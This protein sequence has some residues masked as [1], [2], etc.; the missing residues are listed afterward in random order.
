MTLIS[1]TSTSSAGLV[2]KGGHSVGPRAFVRSRLIPATAC[3]VL[4]SCGGNDLATGESATTA[5]AACNA[6]LNQQFEGATITKAG[7][8][9]AAGSVPEACVVRGELPKELAFE[10]RMPTTWNNRVLFMGGGGFDGIIYETAYSPGV[11]EKGYA[12]IATNHGHDAAKHPQG[13]FAL[14]AQ[15]LEDYA[16]AAVPKVL[17]SAKAI[18]HKRYGGSLDNTR[19]VYEGCSGGGRQGL[20]QAQRHPDLFDGIIARAPANA[21][22]GQFLW[23]Q[24]ILR[25]L[26]KPGA[27]LSVGKVRTI[28]NFIQSRCDE[29]DGLKDNIISRPDACKVDLTALRCNAA[30]SDACLTDAQLESARTLYEPT[31]VAGGRYT[32]PAFPQGG[33]ETADDASWQA[34]GGTTYQILGGDYM[35]YFVAQDPSVDPLL[36]EPQAYTTRLDYLANL[37]DAVN[38]DLGGFRARNG[39]LM[40]FHGTTDW[41]IT[42]NNTTDYYNKLV[43]SAGGQSAADQFVEYYVLPGNDHCAATPN[44]GRGP[45]MVDLVN[46]MF[47]WIEKGV[48]PSSRK[49][50]ATRSVDPGKGMER[51]LCRYPRYPAYNG[52]GDPNAASSF[53]CVSPD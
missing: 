50:V 21:Y 51:P 25:Q 42:L 49:I 6:L 53:T 40:L 16:Y 20:I 19:F 5:E 32:W 1:T 52:S 3:L 9:P 41:L 43:A 47:E 48:K 18:L 27:A 15:M 2:H 28:A 36:V 33:G 26:A 14:D 23:Y 46:P 7:L 45:D 17:A 10:V 13:S 37:I 38:P 4:A 35:R 11:A 29:L 34:V 30:D 31:S 24:K 39:K 8:V 44:G 22:T 12:T